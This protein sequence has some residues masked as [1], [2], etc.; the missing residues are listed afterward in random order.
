MANN[1][2]EPKAAPATGERLLVS[3]G[4]LRSSADPR[5]AGSWQARKLPGS[6]QDGVRLLAITGEPLE[7]RRRSAVTDAMTILWAP[8]GIECWLELG[9]SNGNGGIVP[10]LSPYQWRTPRSLDWKMEGR[11]GLGTFRGGSKLYL[12]LR[13]EEWRVHYLMANLH[14]LLLRGALA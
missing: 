2:T 9:G 13:T 14:A 10:V 6:P 3:G 5:M 1:P 8:D 12:R 4:H 7:Q 11:Q